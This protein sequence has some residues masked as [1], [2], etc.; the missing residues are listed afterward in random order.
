V[1]VLSIDYDYAWSE[2]I[3]FTASRINRFGCRLNI[4]ILNRTEEPITGL[5]IAFQSYLVDEL[6]HQY[7]PLDHTFGW[8][9]KD[10]GRNT[11]DTFTTSSRSQD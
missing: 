5:N 4:R 1:A 3:P 6:W 2:M 10:G 11:H 9:G 7:S 8:I